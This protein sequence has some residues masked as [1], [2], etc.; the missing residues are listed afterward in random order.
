MCV[1]VCVCVF[2]LNLSL[3]GLLTV[4]PLERLSLDAVARSKWLV[5]S[6][7]PR[8]VAC[9]TLPLPPMIT[10]QPLHSNK[11]PNL[12]IPIPEKRPF[13]LRSV[14]G[15]PLAKRRRNKHS[16]SSDSQDS[17]SASDVSLVGS[18]EQLMPIPVA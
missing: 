13:K 12:L 18:T 3:P 17:S 8:P 10:T 15:A 2:V 14:D 5:G 1:C 11:R 6:D 4:N 16:L 7:P 9:S